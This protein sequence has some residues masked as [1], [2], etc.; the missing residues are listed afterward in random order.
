MQLL[1]II[2]IRRA[3]AESPDP[4]TVHLGLHVL[5][6]MGECRYALYLEYLE[7][8]TRNSGVFCDIVNEQE[9][10]PMR[11]RTFDK[12]FKSSDLNDPLQRDLKKVLPRYIF[13]NHLSRLALGHCSSH[14]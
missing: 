10:D 6:L 7:A 12:G 4:G 1:F 14:G 9:Y 11:W 5:N 3:N 13:Q 8:S 2:E